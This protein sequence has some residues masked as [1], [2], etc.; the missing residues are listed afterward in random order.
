MASRIYVVGGPQGIR[1]VSAANKPQAIAYVANTTI[2]AHVA[3]QN[4]LVDLLSAGLVVENVK[5][6]GQVDLPGVE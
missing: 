1:L 3:S 2:R 5:P 6:I 4:D